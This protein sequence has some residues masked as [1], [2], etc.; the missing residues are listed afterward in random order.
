MKFLE[1]ILISKENDKIPIGICY[2]LSRAFDSVN[3][4]ILLE[5]LKKYGVLDTPYINW[6]DSYLS[7]RKW[8]FSYRNHDGLV[9]NSDLKRCEVGLPQGSILGPLLFIVY[10]NDIFDTVE[11]SV[12]EIAVFADD[13]NCATSAKEDNEIEETGNPM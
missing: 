3:P 4:S 5:K 9:F 10:I 11:D 2:D 6:F 1:E 8:F 12:T 13:S 7:S